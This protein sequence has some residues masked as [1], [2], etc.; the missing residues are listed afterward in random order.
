MAGS[1]VAN[2]RFQ[3]SVTEG[4]TILTGLPVHMAN[5]DYRTSAEAQATQMLY[6]RRPNNI[7]Y[8]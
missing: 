1:S 5:Y 8:C 2:S 4:A 3:S 6:R 7:D